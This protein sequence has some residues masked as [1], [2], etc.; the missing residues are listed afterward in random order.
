MG[1]I[2]IRY[3]K[4]IDSGYIIFIGTGNG[5][6]EITEQEYAETLNAIRNKLI[7][8]D[9]FDFRLKTDLTWEE[10]DLPPA[11]PEQLSDE[12]SLTCYASELT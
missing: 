7:S 11:E 3:Y 1:G 6:A 9:G 4:T 2:R 12:E 8:Q 10:Y 5:G